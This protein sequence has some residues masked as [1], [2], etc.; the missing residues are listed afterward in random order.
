MTVHSEMFLLLD[1]GRLNPKCDLR[2]GLEGLGVWL[3]T[4]VTLLKGVCYSVQTEDSRLT[5]S[6]LESSSLAYGTSNKEV[7]PSVLGNILE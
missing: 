3:Q 4:L 2:K 1:M 6:P 7:R 5:E